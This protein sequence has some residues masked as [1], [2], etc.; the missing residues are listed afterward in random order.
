MNIREKTR[1]LL[2]EH[3]IFSLPDPLLVYLN[4]DYYETHQKNW[5]VFSI[6]AD[7]FN[8]IRNADKLAERIGGGV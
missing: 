7:L 1:K 2:N 8:Q 5:T 4:P 6:Q 3:Y